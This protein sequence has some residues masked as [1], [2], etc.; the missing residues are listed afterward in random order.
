MDVKQPKENIRVGVIGT[1]YL[2]KFHAEKYARMD[3]VDLVGVADIDQSAADEVAR[4]HN[5]RAFADHRELL[6]MVDAVSIVVPTSL[7]FDI[8]RDFLDHDVDVLIEKPM[9]TT[10]EQADELVSFAESKGL[11]IQVGHLERFNPA[12]VAL[13]GIV[14]QPMF[15]ESHRLSVYK[16]RALDVSVVLDLMIHDIDLISNFVGARISDVRAAGIPV[17]TDQV[18]IANA[19]LQFDS[20]CVANVT[21]SRVSMKNERKIRLFQRDA[22]IS[23]DFANHGITLVR[24]NEQ[25]SDSLIPGMEIQ[26]LQFEK[27]DALEDELKAFVQAVAGRQ[28]P[29]VDGRVG[30]SALQIALHVMDQIHTTNIRHLSSGSDYDNP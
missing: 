3:N 18:D 13:R 28:T 8:S 22:Y 4:R 30:R 27:G 11:I 9:T 19:R 17:I 23:V 2:G 15:I 25:V 5:T 26:Q 20:G 1:G 6:P 10:L 14:N 16:E 29:E 12:V 24:R 21:A 7:H